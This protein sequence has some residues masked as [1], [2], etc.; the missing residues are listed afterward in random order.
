M[1]ETERMCVISKDAIPMYAVIRW[2]AY[3]EI[4]GKMEKCKELEQTV[5][6]EQMEGEYNIDINKIPV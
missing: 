4:L 1:L 3:Q 2:D 5:N 6:E